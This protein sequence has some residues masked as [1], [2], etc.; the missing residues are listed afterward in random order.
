MSIDEL[1]TNYYNKKEYKKYLDLYFEKIMEINGYNKKNY[2][3]GEMSELYNQKET[4]LKNNVFF[5]SILKIDLNDIDNCIYVLYFMNYIYKANAPF[6]DTKEKFKSLLSRKELNFKDDDYENNLKIIIENQSFVE[7]IKEI[8]KCSSVKNYFE[9]DFGFNFIPE[10]SEINENND[11]FLKEGFNRLLDNLEKDNNYLK[12]IIVFKYLP[13]YNRAF[14]DPNMRIVINPLYFEFSQSLDQNKRNNIFR[15]YLII[16]ILHEIV[17]LLKFMKKEKISFDNILKTPKGKECG[18]MFINYLFNLPMIY[19]ITD[20]QA[21]IINEP[22]NWDNLSLLSN[23]FKEQKDWYEKNK[24]DIDDIFSRPLNKNNNYIS[25]Y[26]SLLDDDVNE[27]KSKEIIDD[28]YDM[29]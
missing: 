10:E 18:K 19:Y 9:K 1:E 24:K 3:S 17:H 5:S 15:S 20:E 22:K 14:V 8:L 7:N 29:D 4:Q 21:S 6:F 27:G 12:K 23:V 28:W 11:D 16:I 26:L 25:F 13:K 2:K